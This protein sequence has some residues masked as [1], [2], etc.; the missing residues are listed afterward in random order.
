LANHKS[1]VKRIR[2]SQKRRMHNKGI[3]TAMRTVVKKGRDALEGGDAED[4]RN[5]VR[6][7][8]ASLRRAA[9][10]GIIPKKR[11]SRAVSRMNKRLNALSS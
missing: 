4:A 2:Q 1:A 3:R 7:A 11:A 10:K 9:S 6:E 8:E 5:K